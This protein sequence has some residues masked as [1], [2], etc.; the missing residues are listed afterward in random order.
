M[1]RAFPFKIYNKLGFKMCVIIVG[2]KK[3]IKTSCGATDIAET[4]YI[5][6]NLIFFLHKI[7][8]AVDTATALSNARV[9][10]YT[11]FKGS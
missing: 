1:R 9:Y 7:A 3:F 10:V 6:F 2:K 8:K 11:R 5:Q 4:A